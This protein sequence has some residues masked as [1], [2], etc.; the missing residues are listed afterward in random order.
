[1]TDRETEQ[2]LQQTLAPEIPDEILN[3]NLKRR[4]EEK[5]MKSSEKKHFTVK[6]A[7]ILAAACSLLVGTV[8]VA[9][10]G[11][12]TTLMTAVSMDNFSSKSFDRLPEA[13]Q[14]A[15]FE[16]KALEKFSNGYR[17]T[18]V[19]TMA[20]KGVDESGNTLD[21]YKE[22]NMRYEKAGEYSLSFYA[23][24]ASHVH[25][26]ERPAKQTAEIQGIKVNYYV[27]TY[28]MVPPGYEMT[29]QDKKN[30][31]KNDYYIS[32]G[33]DEITER[34]FTS[35]IWCQDDISYQILCT[36]GVVPAQML[37]AMAEELIVS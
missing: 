4:M 7:V 14:N 3:R 36:D 20:T 12:I 11:K 27:D 9:S 6:R 21:R 19:D 10:S 13:E 37:F 2:I 33:A 24:E 35:V 1:M 8:G 15:G 17:F 23:M 34:Q 26:D 32:E 29:E 28:K 18:E 30:L 22:I 31:E 5:N 25:G 16:I